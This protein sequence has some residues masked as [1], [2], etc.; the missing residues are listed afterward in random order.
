MGDESPDEELLPADYKP[1]S[2]RP[3]WSDVQPL[4]Q[5]DGENP[6]V[7]IAYS[8]K[9]TRTINRILYDFLKY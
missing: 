3:E 9:C 6:V 2:Q 4:E 7:M 8:D 1:Y 5:D